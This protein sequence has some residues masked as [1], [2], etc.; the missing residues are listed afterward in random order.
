MNPY[1]N[2]CVAFI[3]FLEHCSDY[4]LFSRMSGHPFFLALSAFLIDARTWLNVCR[5]V[6]VITK[7]SIRHA[8]G[9]SRAAG[10]VH[11]SFLALM[12]ARRYRPIMLAFRLLF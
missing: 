4:L 9:F 11:S 3:P 8:V 7:I 1:R 5:P 12:G 2:P 10:H 6:G